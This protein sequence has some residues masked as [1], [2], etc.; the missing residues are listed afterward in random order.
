[1]PTLDSPKGLKEPLR[2]LIVGDPGA[3]KTTAYGHLLNHG[4]KLFVADFDK[5][6]DPVRA[7]AK[8]EFHKNL[9]YET[10]VD[11]VR[12]AP[13]TGY[14]IAPNPK[15]WRNFIKL[16][17]NWTDSETGE[18]FGAP[19]SWDENSWFVVDTLTGAGRA[20]WWHVMDKNG[21]MGISLRKKDWGD[22]V[23]TVEGLPQLL[24][25]YPINTI[26]TAHLARLSPEDDVDDEDK[27]PLPPGVPKI[28]EK[29]V[30]N[31]NLL[32]RY[33]AT[34]G[35]KLPPRIGGYFTVVLQAK[36]V[37]SGARANR[38]ILTK[39]EDDVDVKLP[40]SQDLI[41]DIEVPID[42]LFKIIQALR[43]KK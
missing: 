9:H 7:Y 13:E 3:G 11:K 35:Q 18:S 15:A 10:L 34:V 40:V 17:D 2:I 42:G 22:I 26:M 4:Q 39:P 25:S 28:Q 37:G 41:R 1:M 30:A 5:G 8:Q 24:Q 14:P 6:L 32:K 21:R 31:E 27:K 33:P 43:G 29:K 38:V 20:A 36:R 12:F 19:E 16:A 23:R